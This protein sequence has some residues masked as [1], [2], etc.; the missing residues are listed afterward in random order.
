MLVDVKLVKK[1]R[2]M[3]LEKCAPLRELAG[4]VTL[5]RGNRLSITPVTARRVEAFKRLQADL[6]PTSFLATY[7][8]LG[9]FVGFFAGLLAIG[10]GI[11]DRRRAR[12]HVRRVRLLA[13]PGAA[14][15]SGTSLAAMIVRRPRVQR[16]H[17]R[18]GAVRWDS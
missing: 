1:T 12:P 11:D 7:A 18:H 10:G 3:R 2:L 5:R 8:A 6:P 15:R 9:V 4:M 13:R 17:H 14:C 16:A